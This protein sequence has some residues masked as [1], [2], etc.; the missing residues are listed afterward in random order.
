MIHTP[1]PAAASPRQHWRYRLTKGPY[2]KY[3][4]NQSGAKVLI[5]QKPILKLCPFN[6]TKISYTIC[7]EEGDETMWPLASVVPPATLILNSR[8]RL[9]GIQQEIH[10]E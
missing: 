7:Y 3:L 6:E 10:T 4:K 5:T 9:G 8:Q 2:S 1:G